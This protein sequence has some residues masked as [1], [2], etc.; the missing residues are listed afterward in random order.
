MDE[1][2]KPEQ[3]DTKADIGNMKQSYENEDEL[4]AAIESASISSSSMPNSCAELVSS[5]KDLNAKLRK[6]LLGLKNKTSEKR[7]KRV[8]YRGKN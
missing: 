6:E 1:T 7:L 4:M 5:F 8:D 2:C 3:P